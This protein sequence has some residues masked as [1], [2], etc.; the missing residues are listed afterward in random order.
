MK[1]I[2]VT[3]HCI[4]ILNIIK[5]GEAH[6]KHN[7][8]ANDVSSEEKS[9]H[10]E[11]TNPKSGNLFRVYAKH[12]Y[13]F[14][15][16]PQ[17]Q[18]VGLLDYHN[19]IS[20]LYDGLTGDAFGFS[21][22]DGRGV[23]IPAGTSDKTWIVKKQSYDEYF[24]NPVPPK[25]IFSIG[26]K[27][28]YHF[29]PESIP[30]D[31]SEKMSKILAPLSVDYSSQCEALAT[32]GHISKISADKLKTSLSGFETVVG[33]VLSQNRGDFK[34][35]VGLFQG[36]GD[37]FAPFG[38]ME[39]LIKKNIKLNLTRI[40]TEETGIHVMCYFLE[41]LADHLDLGKILSETLNNPV[42]F[43]TVTN[44]LGGDINYGFDGLINIIK[45][46]IMAKEGNN[47]KENLI[48]VL[49]LYFTNSRVKGDN[50]GQKWRTSIQD[51]DETIKK[52]KLE[53]AFHGL[54]KLL[55]DIGDQKWC[56][57]NVNMSEIVEYI[58]GVELPAD[59]NVVYKV[60][61]KLEL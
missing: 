25:E 60:I 50:L 39:V 34:W 17:Q 33:D 14:P 46:M 42:E 32:L 19:N 2:L 11:E 8:N 6:G 30:E 29:D 44:K 15:Y 56:L 7:S 58:V 18:K 31:M 3:I 16:N 43:F 13:Y 9:Q 52:L 22:E 21:Y 35:A 26:E 12:G 53:K 23:Y 49:K 4:L 5:L 54:T 59:P 36:M 20:I 57:G 47:S 40:F 1:T 48:V 38:N 51:L 10:C 55:R 24:K 27:H 41:E 37:F 45:E 61:E 28:G